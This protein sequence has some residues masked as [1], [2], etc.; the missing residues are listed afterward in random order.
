[1]NS[2]HPRESGEPGFSR[3]DGSE[4]IAL[5]LKTRLTK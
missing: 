2:A 5:V 4:K 3:L 1:M